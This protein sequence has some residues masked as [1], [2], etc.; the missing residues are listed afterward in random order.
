MSIKKEKV[1]SVILVILIAIA[2]RFYKLEEIP[3]GLNID[4]ASMGYN[5]YSLLQTGKDRYGEMFPILFRS[6]GSFQ[7]PLYTYLSI[8]PVLIFDNPIFAIHFVA[9]VSG[10]LVVAATFLILLRN[11]QR[12]RFKVAIIGALLVGICPWAV[13][14]SRFGTEAILGL[15]L[16]L[17]GVLFCLLSLKRVSFLIVGTFFLGLA[18]HAYYSER[19]IS[20]LF[21][22]G[23]LLLFKDYFLKVRKVVV[24]SLL[25]F[26]ILMVPHVII[27][28]S[29]AL[30]RRLDQVAYFDK[31]FFIQNAGDFFRSIPGGRVLYIIREFLSQYL[32]YFS[33]RN[34]FF[35]PDPQGGR[36]I[37]DLSVFYIWMIVPFIVGIRYLIQ[38]IAQA[39]VRIMLLLIIIAPI[40]AALTR[41]PFYT[42]RTLVLLWSQTVVITFGVYSLLQSIKS[43]NLKK[44]LIVSISIYSIVNLYINY[45]VLLKYERAET[46]NN[47]YI[48]LL[49]KIRNIDEQ[50]V[51]VDTSRDLAVGI[52]YAYLLKYD[53]VVVQTEYRS[54]LSF[55]YYSSGEVVETYNLDKIKARPIDWDEDADKDL[56]LIGDNLA[57]SEQ[58][59]KEHKLSEILEI[60]D[61]T[62][63][64]KLKGY[65]TNVVTK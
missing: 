28:N 38:N 22:V 25:I 6:F 14:F 34:L 9:A 61:F 1:I 11:Q 26:G 43:I 21:I 59:V 41:D 50:T 8:I 64:V 20:V 17:L 54:K 10:V 32:A 63:T 12:E 48:R 62:D 30:T 27:S 5:A 3:N 2:T 57:I 29:G 35:D 45:F 52:I 55:P 47:T 19:I 56:I 42:L 44:V 65:Q 4:E 40:P 33:L 16:F 23:F 53:P 51:V 13:T 18:T 49:D 7:A 37:P 24:I 36:S 58:Q 60:R 46:F 31:A 39:F 15:S